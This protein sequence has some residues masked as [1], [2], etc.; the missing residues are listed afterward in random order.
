MLFRSSG[1]VV[2]PLSE[3]IPPPHTVDVAEALACRR[4]V[5]FAKEL[6]IKSVTVE[7]DSG[8]VIKSMNMDPPCLAPFGHIIEDSQSMA[9]YFESI[10]FSHVRRK[11]KGMA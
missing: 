1:K 7:V 3:R 5:S 4:A 2:G 10:S 8:K 11:G 6:G 9:L